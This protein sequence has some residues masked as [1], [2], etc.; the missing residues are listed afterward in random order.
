MT[1]VCASR[2]AGTVLPTTW[3][4]DATTRLGFDDRSTSRPERRAGGDEN[5]C[6]RRTGVHAGVRGNKDLARSMPP[7]SPSCR[8]HERRVEMAHR[9]LELAVGRGLTPG[10]N[11]SHCLR[12]TR[13][14]S[15]PRLISESL[16]P[17]LQS[18]R[19]IRSD[20]VGTGTVRYRRKSC[21]RLFTRC[22]SSRSR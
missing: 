1:H 3:Q 14:D 10:S 4:E 5:L 16:L 8:D 11:L 7:R 12:Y 9:K 20:P 13:N 15:E 19:H 17:R 21:Q 2:G 6:E 18:A 22:R